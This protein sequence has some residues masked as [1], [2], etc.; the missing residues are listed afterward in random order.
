M[1]FDLL[2]AEKRKPFL[3][4]AESVL[5]GLDKLN[6]RVV[7]KVLVNEEAVETLLRSRIDTAVEGF[8]AGIK[9]WKKGAIPQAE[10]A[11]RMFAVFKNL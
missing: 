5:V 3:S 10:L 7:P 4:L 6:L 2:T 8:F 9:V 11:S 1:S